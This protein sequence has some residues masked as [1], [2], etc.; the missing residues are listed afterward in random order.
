MYDADGQVIT[1]QHVVEGASS[2]RVMLQDGNSYP[3]TV[4]GADPSTDLAVIKVDAPAELLV[5][6]ELGDSDALEVG[7]GVVAIGSP[8]G[9]EGSVT[10]GIVSA[11]HREMRSPNGFSI[12]DS[13]QTDAAINH[14]N[15][16]GPLLDLRARSSA[17]TLRSRATP[18]ATRVSASRSP[19][20]V[21][22]IASQL[23][24]SGKVEH[25]FL[26]VTLQQ[27]P[28]TSPTRWTAPRA[29]GRRFARHPG[30]TSRPQGRHGS[31]DRGRRPVPDR[32]RQS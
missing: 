30:R 20:T 11:L 21:S 10:S 5:P 29:R 16:G 19:P 7:D 2:V 13:I 27:I 15:S 12:D 14:G 18:A 8:F 1:N 31:E 26:G 17:S 25:A 22:S 3:A 23:I 28:P 6:L 4:V 32:W 24:S 9:L